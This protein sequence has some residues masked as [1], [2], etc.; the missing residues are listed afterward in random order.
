[1]KILWVICIIMA[2]LS[3][4]S[5]IARIIAFILLCIATIIVIKQSLS[6]RTKNSQKEEP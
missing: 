5:P 1:M 6:K 3:R 4:E 2:L